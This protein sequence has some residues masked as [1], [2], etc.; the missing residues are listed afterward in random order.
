MCPASARLDIVGGCLV[1]GSD[2]EQVRPRR[3]AHYM[4]PV[5][6]KANVHFTGTIERAVTILPDYNKDIGSV[7]L[8]QSMLDSIQMITQQDIGL[9]SILYCS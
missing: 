3:D 4:D 8:Y 6:S 2:M 7:R 1:V 9:Q 5:A